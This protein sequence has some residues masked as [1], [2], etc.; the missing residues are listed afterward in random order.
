[1]RRLGIAGEP[2]LLP[3]PLR[4][5]FQRRRHSRGWLGSEVEFSA[6]EDDAG[7]I[8]EEISIPLIIHSP[9]E[10]GDSPHCV[11]LFISLR[12]TAQR[13][14]KR[15]RNSFPK[16]MRIRVAL[17]DEAFASALDLVE[18][19]LACPEKGCPD[20]ARGDDG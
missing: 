3:V 15:K 19:L 9:E 8:V 6:D 10:T 5:Q 4:K 13:Q 11:C 17:T 1:M 12:A 20:G 14:M 2:L 18:W 7:A 16:G